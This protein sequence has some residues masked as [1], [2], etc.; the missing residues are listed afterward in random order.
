MLILFVGCSLFAT[1]CQKYCDDLGVA[2]GD[3]LDNA[4]ESVDREGLSGVDAEGN[5]D[6]ERYAEACSAAPEGTDCETCTG[7][8]SSTFLA[9]LGVTDA[10]DYAYGRTDNYS[11]GEQACEQT[12]NTQGLEF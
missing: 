11:G 6:E 8:Y 5:L 4:S 7:W 9:P 3:M 2:Y 1:P 12:C 10:C